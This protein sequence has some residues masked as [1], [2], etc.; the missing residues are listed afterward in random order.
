M[1]ERRREIE[2]GEREVGRGRG[3]GGRERE[4]RGGGGKRM[5]MGEGGKSEMGGRR[6]KKGV[7]EWGGKSLVAFLK[8]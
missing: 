4:G 8:L 2:G 1:R 3:E 6:I 7:K 5:Q